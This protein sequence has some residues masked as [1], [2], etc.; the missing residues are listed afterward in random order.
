MR[1]SLATHGGLAAPIVRR[2]P[3]RVLDAD[4]LPDDDA[5]ELRRLLAAA[6]ADPG[7]VHP[8]RSA[9]D[10]MTYTVTVEDGPHSTTL[11]SS[12]TAMSA[13]FATLLSWLQPRLG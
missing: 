7:G 5:R 10:V 12:D 4:R 1:V 2:L 13:A 8:A 9:R 3:A 6:A 11:T